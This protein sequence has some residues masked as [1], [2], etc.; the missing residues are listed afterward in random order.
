[1]WGVCRI[2]WSRLLECHLPHMLNC[3]S[4]QEHFFLI[5]WNGNHSAPNHP[6]FGTAFPRHHRRALFYCEPAPN[7]PTNQECRCPHLV[8]SLRLALKPYFHGGYVNVLD[9]RHRTY[10][11]QY[12]GETMQ[13]CRPLRG[14]RAPT[15]NRLSILSKASL[16]AP[17]LPLRSLSY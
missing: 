14:R 6:L 10:G 11:R 1:M 12:Y 3:A 16:C 15:E 4:D 17:L 2:P 5:G 7:G 13:D 9:R 8:E